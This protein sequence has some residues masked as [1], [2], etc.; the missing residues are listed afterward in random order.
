MM[1][2]EQEVLLVKII[3]VNSRLPKTILAKLTSGS[4]FRICPWLPSQD[5]ER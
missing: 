5:Q 3:R 1:F 2:V 4:H